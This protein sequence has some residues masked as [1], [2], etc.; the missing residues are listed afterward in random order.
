MRTTTIELLVVGVVATLMTSLGH[1]PIAAD[2]VRDGFGPEAT[3]A[4]MQAYLVCIALVVLPLAVSGLQRREALLA[5]RAGEEQFRRSFTESLIGMLLLRRTADG[6]VVAE[7][8]EVA[9]RQL[10]ARPSQLLGRV[11]RGGLDAADEER[12]QDAAERILSRELDSWAAEVRLPGRSTAVGAARGHRRSTGRGRADAER[13]AGRPHHRAG[14]AG[15][16]EEERDF[17]LAVLDSANTLIIVID[18]EARIVRFNPAAEKLSGYAVRRGPGPTGLRRSSVPPW[19]GG[20]ASTCPLRTP[21]ADPDQV[22][23]D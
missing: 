10:G 7:V 12:L 17:T 14:G 15:R 19:A 20:S 9:A 4:L 1:G 8:N 18:H 11:W 16:L 3:T 5:A 2:Q 23:E 22:E 21:D 13:A 6:M